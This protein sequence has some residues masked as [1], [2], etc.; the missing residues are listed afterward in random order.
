MEPGIVFFEVILFCLHLHLVFLKC[1]D[2][3]ICRTVFTFIAN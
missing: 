1:S 2:M 3:V